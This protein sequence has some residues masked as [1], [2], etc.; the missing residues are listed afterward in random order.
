MEAA[1]AQQGLPETFTVTCALDDFVLDL[2]VLV[3]EFERVQIQAVAGRKMDVDVQFR[4]FT[5]AG[6]L[7]FVETLRELIPFDGFSD[8]PE[9]QV[10]PTGISAGFTTGL[11]N[12]SVGVFSLENLSLGAGFEV[13]FIGKPL[14]TWFK[15][16]TRENP[17]RLTVSLFGG[18]FYLGLTVDADG[19]QVFEGAIEFGAACSV[20]F[21]VASGSVSAMAGLYF[22]FEG[23]D[24]TLAGYFRLRGEVEALGHR[25]GVDRAVPRDALRV[26]RAG[27]A[28]ARRRS[29]SRST[30]PCSAPRSRSART[31]KFAG[32]GSDPTLAELMDVQP[33]ATSTYWNAVLRGVR[34]KAVEQVLWTAL[35]NGTTEDGRLRLSVHVGSPPAQRRR[36]RRR[37]RSSGT[38]PRS[39]T[40]PPAAMTCGSRWLSTAGRPPRASR[41]P[42]ADPVLWDLLFPPEM[43]VGPHVYR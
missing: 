22:K 40:G 10:T 30:S 17:S 41:K 39:C 43:R 38:S 32:S 37:T 28:S 8:P 11:P 9:V 2:E 4:K 31:K 19:L 15:F 25:V 12:L 27:S 29:A 14:S 21:G 26:R 7:S 6:P 20:D 36:Q 34:V 24:M 16:C 18:G 35:P 42:P 1:D 3:L 33:D 23:S 13:P 5:F